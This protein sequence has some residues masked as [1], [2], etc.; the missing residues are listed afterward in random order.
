MSMGSRLAWR[1]VLFVVVVGLTTGMAAS[2]LGT[3]SGQYRGLPSG[4]YWDQQTDADA[5]SSLGSGLSTLYEGNTDQT[6]LNLTQQAAG[7]QATGHAWR[8]AG[9]FGGV[10]DIPNI[11]SGNELFGPVDGIG[12]AIAVDPTDPTGNTVYLG[13]IGG[14]Y[15]TTDG[16]H[17]VRNIADGQMARDS[18]GAIAVDPNDSKTVYAGTGVS[19]FTLS[20]DAAGTGVYVSHDGGSTWAR[21]SAN[22]HGYGVNSIAVTPSGDVLVGTTY[23]L[24]R[25][26]DNG[27]SF[28]Q[29][30]LPDNANHTGPAAHPLGSW[31]TSIVVNPTDGQEVTAAVGFA[32]GKKV[33]PGGD[34]IAPG[35][36]LYRSTNGGASFSYL[37]STSQFTWPGA[38][39]DPFG[40]TTLDYSTVPGSKGLIWALVSDAGKA[41]G[42]HTCVD[43]PAVPVCLD[44]NSSLNGLYRSADDGSTWQLEATSQ[45]LAAA[46]GGTTSA[47]GNAISYGAGV[48]SFYNNWVLADPEDP[49]RVYIGL[50]EAFTGEFHDVTG[51][52][53]V[54]SMT[55]TAMEKYA[56]ACGFLTYF[57]TIPNNNGIACPS[58]IP[59]YGG[60][61]T[62][63]DQH[64]AAITFTPTGLRL[65]SGN[66][67][68][69]WAQD[70]HMVTDATGVGYQGFDNVSWRSLGLPA[71]VL[72][73]DVTRLQ[74]GSLLLA[75][76]DNGVAH[77]RPNGT[78]Y[79]VCGGDGV[80]VFPGAN[81][82]SYYC[83]IDGQTILA[84][85][86]DMAH[87]ITVTPTNNA[88]GATFLSP[89]TVDSNDSNH[90]L[91]A[92]GN[93]DETTQ[94]PK[95][96][97]YDPT[98]TELLNSSWQTVFTPPAAP[99]GSWDSS[100]VYTNGPVSYVAFCSPCRPSLATG[101]VENASIVTPKIA[102]N[103]KP[104]CKA[105]ELAAACWH[106]AASKGLPH[107]QV[108]GIAV[109][110]LDPN[111]MY[112][113][114]RQMIVMGADPKVTGSQK[115]MVSHDGGDNFT[116][117]T[118]NLPQ[119]D[120][121]RIALRKGQLYVATDVG[122]FT[123]P[124]TAP[125][126]SIQWKRFGT[127]LPQVTYRS[128]QLDPTSR[129]LT[130]GA[131]GRGAWTYDF[132][133]QPR[134]FVHA[135]PL[136]TFVNGRGASASGSGST[137]TVAAQQASPRPGNL[138]SARLNAR[139]SSA[140]RHPSTPLV[141]TAALLLALAGSG[142]LS[143]GYR[144]V[145][146]KRGS[147][148]RRSI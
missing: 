16:G 146:S 41:S 31:V 45:T 98:D 121:H 44:G 40:R 73:W 34:V 64:S 120:S 79:Q 140:D 28:H 5:K 101:S 94:G 109:D 116:D 130:L 122:V 23:G 30:P 97:T 39:S 86:D 2:L 20:D 32:F 54:P 51:M 104:Q 21:P 136:Q 110:P 19:I 7:L 67:G 142:T 38:S 126:A 133:G 69:W 143:A 107:E 1:A 112:V 68:G 14:L 55:W 80:Y 57:N 118:G 35:N 17:T 48:Q 100:A 85:T 139:L 137:A 26:T 72:P 42:N 135:T 50:E 84:T 93:V 77:V 144:R 90:L 13:T 58:V 10:V 70:A 24:W 43:T 127:G 49:N 33:Y 27:L 108:S 74:D 15:K 131:Y 37:P 134:S 81:A 123:A 87:T 36:G 106:M 53:P 103:V 62:H 138:S 102:T 18:I 88:T 61:S 141:L 76:Q 29:V 117:L 132:G 56:N 71:T 3:R 9:P 60:G 25:S 125:P 75:L 78:A 119:A 22:T 11:G 96:N 114:L 129:Y 111:T 99:H 95:T 63:P 59:E 145:K 124:T 147:N 91:A 47:A 12:T 4:T 115:V 113:S 148:S 92:A 52:L 66:D 89:W 82:Q 46:T 83:G 65:Y 128:M 8:N 105:A 6:F